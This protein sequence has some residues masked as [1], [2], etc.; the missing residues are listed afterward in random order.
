MSPPLFLC[1]SCG[2]KLENSRTVTPSTEQK[3]FFFSWASCC[4][5]LQIVFSCEIKVGL[6][7]SK[8]CHQLSQLKLILSAL[9]TAKGQSHLLARKRFNRRFLHASG[10]PIWRR[11]SV[12]LVSENFWSCRTF[13][14]KVCSGGTLHSPDTNFF[15]NQIQHIPTVAQWRSYLLTCK[16]GVQL[17]H[18]RAMQKNSLSS[19]FIERHFYFL[20]IRVYE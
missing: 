2:L 8:D 20:L 12:T 1:L 6:D 10:K 13:S 19:L 5:V 4:G 14:V 9:I 7:W 18:R 16:S 15:D 17:A 3:F 11:L